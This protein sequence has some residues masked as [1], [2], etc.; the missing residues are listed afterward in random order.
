MCVSVCI[1]A[2]VIQHAEHILPPYH[3]TVIRGLCACIV[4]FHMISTAQ[5]YEKKVTEQKMCDK[6]HGTE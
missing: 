6:N 1:L 5:F 3:Y 2:L 4:F